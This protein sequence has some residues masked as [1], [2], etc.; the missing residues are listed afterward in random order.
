MSVAAAYEI[1]EWQFAV[2]EGGDAGI[3]SWLQA[4]SGMHKKTC[5][6]LWCSG[7]IG[8]VLVLQIPPW[9]KLM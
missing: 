7:G 2:I 8:T 4:T 9:R 6:A 3:G 5:A 1:I